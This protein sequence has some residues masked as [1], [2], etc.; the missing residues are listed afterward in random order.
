MAYFI[1][2]LN[3]KSLYNLFIYVKKN[4]KER[5]DKM[6]NDHIIYNAIISNKYVKI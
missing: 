3:Q 4:T 1:I 5:M 2:I 6:L